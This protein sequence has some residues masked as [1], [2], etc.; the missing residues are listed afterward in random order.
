MLRDGV[1]LRDLDSTNGSF[2]QGT[3]FREIVAS[4]GAVIA[5]GK[6][7]LR[8]QVSSSGAG[9][10]PSANESFGRLFGR[11]LP[12]RAAF[13]LLERVAPTDVSVILE[14]ETGTGKEL[15]AEA[16]HASSP[17]KGGPLVIVDLAGVPANLIESELFGHV[18][19]SFTG[20]IADRAGAFER[21]HGGTVFLDEIGELPLELQPRLLRALE[22]RTTKRVGSNDYAPFDVRVVC[23]THRDL[24]ALIAAGKF[25]DDLY[26][27]LAVVKIGLPPL[28]ERREDIPLLVERLLVAQ[29]HPGTLGPQTMAALAG[30][31]W[32]G[33]V[34]ELRNVVERV[35]SL[36]GGAQEVPVELL[37]LHSPD[38]EAGRRRGRLQGGARAA[39]RGVRARLPRL[40]PRALPP[41]RLAG[42][43]RGGARPGVRLPALEEARPVAA[44]V[45]SARHGAVALAQHP[46]PASARDH[47]GAARHTR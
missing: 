47:E 45:L 30:Y 9:L 1:L 27:R 33:N 32:P 37:G 18:R 20:A 22:S 40:A 7:T 10:Q 11:S 29:G 41:Q 35:I 23:A 31:D 28:R 34:R 42:R 2:C 43:A 44:R 24:K 13:S 17:R 5:I 8:L 21:A 14:G 46:G 6:S 16:I 26:H 12:M 15:C 3:R 38:S 19:G 39:A 4:P 36:G 25:R